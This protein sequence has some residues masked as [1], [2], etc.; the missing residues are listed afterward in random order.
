MSRSTLRDTYL[1]PLEAKGLIDFEDDL[2]DKRKKT[3]AV[4]GTIQETSLIND[5][6]FKKRIATRA[7]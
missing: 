1:K 4:K 7:G 6:E 3:I 5:L 2:Q